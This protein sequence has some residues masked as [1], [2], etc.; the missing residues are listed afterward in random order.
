MGVT[1][2]KK[3]NVDKAERIKAWLDQPK[4]VQADF[5]N[6]LNYLV[7][8]IALDYIKSKYIGKV[9]YN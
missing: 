5:E 6:D 8:Q 1:V 7:D 9:V 4:V 2:L 3:L